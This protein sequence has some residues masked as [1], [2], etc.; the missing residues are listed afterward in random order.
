MPSIFNVR[1]PLLTATNELRPRRAPFLSFW[2]G[3]RQ[4]IGSMQADAA[5]VWV[6][7]VAAHRFVQPAAVPS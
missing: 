7:F 2:L 5:A 1:M 6:A 3:R 4:S